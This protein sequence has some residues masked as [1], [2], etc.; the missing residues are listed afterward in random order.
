V[1]TSPNITSAIE[2]RRMRWARHV[3]RV[4]EVRNAFKFWSEDP[5]VDVK[6]TLEWILGK[7]CGKEWIG[8]IWLRI[9]SSGGLL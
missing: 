5:G 1:C 8:L 2:L 6:T 7:Q 4:G 9:W 3:A